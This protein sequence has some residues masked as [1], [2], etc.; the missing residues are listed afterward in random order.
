MSS[1][2][3]DG[4]IRVWGAGTGVLDAALGGHSGAVRALAVAA[5]RVTGRDD[6][7]VGAGDKGGAADDGG[8]LARAQG[9]LMVG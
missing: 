6:S 2:A 3:R 4:S 5:E 7:G 1:G 9:C 8:V